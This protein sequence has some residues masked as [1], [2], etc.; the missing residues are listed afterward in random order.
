M[1]FG[2][3]I[4]LADIGGPFEEDLI[5]DLFNTYALRVKLKRMADRVMVESMQS[6]LK[7]VP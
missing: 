7:K 4:D 1:L 6:E 3:N 2:P 5:T